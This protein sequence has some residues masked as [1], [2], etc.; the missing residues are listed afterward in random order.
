M[1]TL[2][3]FRRY[4]FEMEALADLAIDQ[5]VKPLGKAIRWIE[6]V[7]RCKGAKH[8]R[9]PAVDMPLYQYLLLDAPTFLSFLFY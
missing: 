1:S 8:L 6:H 3:I 2:H 9:N 7:I 5:P 4:R